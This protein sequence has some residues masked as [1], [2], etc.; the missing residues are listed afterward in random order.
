MR[1]RQLSRIDV[2]AGE[3]AFQTHFK[4]V[5]QLLVLTVKPG[6]KVQIGEN[7]FVV[8]VRSL[9]NNIKIGIEAPRDVQ[10]VREDAIN[11]TPRKVTP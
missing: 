10:I 9:P 8:V 11:R 1:Q 2:T 7:I 4:G 5:K 3:T 6:E